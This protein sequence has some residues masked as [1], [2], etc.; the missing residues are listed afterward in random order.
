MQ[1]FYHLELQSQPPSID[2]INQT[3]RPQPRYADS[4]ALITDQFDLAD[5]KKELA[6]LGITATE[7]KLWRWR[8]APGQEEYVHTDG[9]RSAAINWCLTANSRLEFFDKRGAVTHT[10]NLKRGSV[11][12]SAT[13][14]FWP[15][16]PCPIPVAVWDSAGPVLIDPQQ[17]HK[18]KSSIDSP[19]TRMTLSLKLE[20]SYQEAWEL[21][22]SAGRIKNN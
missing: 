20:H 9:N 5:I 22:N 6:Q 11:N 3:A 21:L 18:P 19:Q 14:W 12:F 13:Y 7:L 10:E 8:L 15:R 2:E 4:A 1:P 17:P 16:I